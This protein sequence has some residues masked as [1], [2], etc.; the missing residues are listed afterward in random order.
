[1]NQNK[2]A[3][4]GKTGSKARLKLP[5]IV[6]ILSSALLALVW[7]ATCVWP[8]AA[9]MVCYA[10]HKHPLAS[11][12]P[13]ATRILFVGNSLTY[14]ENVPG[15]FAWMLAKM[16]PAEHFDVEAYTWPDSTLK[17][18]SE[19]EVVRKL[20]KERRDYIIVQEHSSAELLK[21]KDRFEAS[22]KSFLSLIGDEHARPVVIMTWADRDRL[23]TRI[24]IS[25]IYRQTCRELHVAMVP[26][27][28][29]FYYVQKTNP[30]I[31][32]YQKDGHHPGTAGAYL[33]A[34]AL[35]AQ[36]FGD[37]RLPE[38]GLQ[39]ESGAPLDPGLRKELCKSL[40]KFRQD[41]RE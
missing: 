14:T 6:A 10:G 12:A 18:H 41:Y 20:L 26:L 40:R 36:L 24:Y 33:Y 9:S 1:M 15:V 28:D 25:W 19:R 22:L 23:K 39:D 32:L 34:L 35:Y 8:L 17:Q 30:Q 11:N 37:N 38:N 29:L 21:G 16:R 4:A 2:A 3:T 27:G 7:S 13:D 5:L 31:D